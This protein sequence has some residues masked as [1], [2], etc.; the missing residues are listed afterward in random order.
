MSNP[1]KSDEMD[2]ILERFGPVQEECE[3]LGG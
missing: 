1:D 2:R 3:H